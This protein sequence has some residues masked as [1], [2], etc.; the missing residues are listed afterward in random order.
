M[1]NDSIDDQ[2][3]ELREKNWVISLSI[4][5]QANKLYYSNKMVD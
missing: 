3:D 2:T 1:D 4:M 5:G